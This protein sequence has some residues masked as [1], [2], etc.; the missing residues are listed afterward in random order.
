MPEP[1]SPLLEV[2]GLGLDLPDRGAAGGF[3]PQPLRPILSDID[4]R[5]S[6]G[7]CLGLV[8]ESGS[9][10]TT[11][12]RTVLRLHEPQRGDI[13]LAGAISRDSTNANCGPC[14]PACR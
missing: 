7:E 4:L 11:L 1:T 10:K 13:V 2:T 14:A 8:G 12:A 6:V 3:G 5:V 9:G